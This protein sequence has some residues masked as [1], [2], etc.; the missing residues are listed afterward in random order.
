MWR[1]RGWS[2]VLLAT[3][4]LSACAG[5]AALSEQTERAAQEGNAQAQ[6][7]LASMYLYG[8]GVEQN[9][10]RAVEWFLKAALQGHVEAQYNL[11]KA[12]SEGI[13]TGADR[14]AAEKWYRLAAE[15]GSAE[16]QFRLGR[17]LDRGDPRSEAA[18][19]YLAAAEQRH[20]AAQYHLGRLYREHAQQPSDYLEAYVWLR[21][22]ADFDDRAY[23][24]LEEMV[25]FQRENGEFLIDRFQIKEAK[26]RIAAWL[27]KHQQ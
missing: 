6:F 22:A 8:D 13:G 26:A 16:A 7:N 15:Q 12:F 24:L 9:A 17:L 4:L 14:E 25:G 20:A 21:L 18:T 10:E 19:W 1:S 5:D 2:L 23:K 27:E 3:L 11:G